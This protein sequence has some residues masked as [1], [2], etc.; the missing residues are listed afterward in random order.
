MAKISPTA[1]AVGEIFAD[2]FHTYTGPA[3]V[4]TWF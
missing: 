2:Y 3:G 1:D 4:I